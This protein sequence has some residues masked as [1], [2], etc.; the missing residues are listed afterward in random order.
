MELRFFEIAVEDGGA[1]YRGEV[2]E[3]ELD[4]DDDLW[5]CGVDMGRGGAVC[6]IN[7]F[8]G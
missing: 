6:A 1:C 8:E 7:D 3:D 4:R 5:V 2:E